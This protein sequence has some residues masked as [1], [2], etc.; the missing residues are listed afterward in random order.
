MLSEDV[1]T[2]SKD[3]VRLNRRRHSLDRRINDLAAQLIGVEEVLAKLTEIDDI[4]KGV[5][6]GC[7]F[8][9][10]YTAVG[11][12]ISRAASVQRLGAGD[13][14][15]VVM[16]YDDRLDVRSHLT[17]MAALTEDVARTTAKLWV[18]VGDELLLPVGQSSTSTNQD[19]TTDL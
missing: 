3:V 8:G 13:V 9:G 6:I 10:L 1:M 18:A 16:L 11:D 17:T 19:R 14:G 15:W 2:L 12:D 4:V 7:T 5:P